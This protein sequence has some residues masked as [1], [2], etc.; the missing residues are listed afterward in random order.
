EQSPLSHR[1]DSLDSEYN[2]NIRHRHPVNTV[3]EEWTSTLERFAKGSPIEEPPRS[4]PTSFS[5]TMT[6]K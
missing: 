5:K 6:D 2:L 3:E 4:A 1:T